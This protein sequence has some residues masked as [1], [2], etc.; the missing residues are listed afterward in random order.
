MI[1]LLKLINGVE[2]V[3]DAILNDDDM[4][5]LRNP[6]V[7]NYKFYAGPIPSVT[8]TKYC[9]FTDDTDITFERSHIINQV[10][11]RDLF[12]KFYL[13]TV[14]SY[15]KTLDDT[16]DSELSSLSEDATTNKFYKQILEDFSV[17]G[18]VQN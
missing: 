11:P 8:F 2:V 4:V 15:T 16:I 1:T 13:N 14:D 9:M 5:V 6:M 10:K 18:I 12:E 3:G 7:I 17:E